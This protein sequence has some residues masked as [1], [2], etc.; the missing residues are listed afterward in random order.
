MQPIYYD[1]SELYFRSGTKIKYYGIARVVAEIA[2]EVSLQ[3]PSVQFVVFDMG[4]RQFFLVKPLFGISSANGLVDLGLPPRGIPIKPVDLRHHEL[5]LRR[6]IQN[7]VQML[8]NT[9]NAARFPDIA[10]YLEKVDLIDGVLFSAAR[11]KYISEMVRFLEERGSRVRLS[12]MLY[13]IFPLHE[14]LSTPERFRK[15]FVFDNTVIMNSADQVLSISHF[16]DADIRE[17]VR[18]GLL[19]APKS[20]SVVQLCHEC[21]AD[22]GCADIQLPERPYFMGVGITMGRKNLDIVLEAI[23]HMLDAGKTPPLF[24]VAGIARA[25]SR[26]ALGNG[27]YVRAEPYVRFVTSPSQANLIKLYENALGTVMASRVEG[28]GL[29]LGESLWLG[30]PAISAPNSSL[31]EVGGDLAIYFDPDS[32]AELA[33]IFDRMMTD[34][35]WNEALRSRVRAAKPFLRR[36]KDVAREVLDVV[37]RHD[38]ALAQPTAA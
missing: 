21:R 20:R 10:N 7:S 12:A 16:T 15:A 22:G 11:P 3:A 38:M 18:A 24:V 2:Y 6:F 26:K 35:T 8:A 29:P 19:P 5:P 28:W 14:E 37:C 25:R 31:R 32:A 36:W 33:A 23:V 13:D 30:T 1:L 17:A 4:R 9:A 27:A 34:T